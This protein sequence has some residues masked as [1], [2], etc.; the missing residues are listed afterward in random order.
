MAAQP[1][2]STT[3][4][5]PILTAVLEEFAARLNIDGSSR[6]LITDPTL[7]HHLVEMTRPIATAYGPKFTI[8]VANGPTQTPTATG[9][10]DLGP[11]VTTELITALESKMDHFTHALADVS[12]ASGKT[13]MEIMKWA[14]YALQPKGIL[15]AVALLKT[16]EGREL[17]ERL[18]G[19]S[20]GRVGGLG[21]VLDFAGFERGKVR[22]ME[23]GEGEGKAEVV[24]AMKWDQLTA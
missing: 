4:A 11:N 24:L 17:G 16:A 10:E 15:V 1:S 6:I 7:A 20:K 13:C 9:G 8:A 5:L 23:R 22:V 12:L 3:P 21:D 14:R 18:R 2:P 19:E